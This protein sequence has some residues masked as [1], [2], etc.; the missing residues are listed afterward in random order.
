MDGECSEQY[1][2]FRSLSDVSDLEHREPYRPKLR[3][4][5]PS[6][7]LPSRVD[8]EVEG[9]R[10]LH[11]ETDNCNGVEALVTRPE[12]FSLHEGLP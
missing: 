10:A 8:I 12:S 4:V 7:R 5:P 11:P 1:E 9:M 3:P 2:Y 6:W